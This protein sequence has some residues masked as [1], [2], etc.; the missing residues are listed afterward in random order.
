MNKVVFIILMGVSL[1][2]FSK[3]LN[4]VEDTSRGINK[5]IASV[6]GDI[7]TLR[8]LQEFKRS[9]SID[10]SAS[11]SG[12]QALEN[13]IEEKLIVQLAEKEKFRVD[14]SLVDKKM[15]QLISAYGGYNKLEESLAKAGLSTAIIIKK[16]KDNLL[17]REAV[18]K[19]VGSKISISPIEVTEYY[20]KHVKEFS[21]LPEYICWITK[22]GKKDFLDGLSVKIKEEGFNQ[23]LTE[24]K[25]IFFRV[26]S[27]EKG[28]NDEVKEVVKSIKEGQWKIKY[29]EGAYYL[30]YLSKIVPGHKAFINEVR[31]KIYKRLWREKFSKKFEEWIKELKEKSVIK[32]YPAE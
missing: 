9:S 29:I 24:R 17:I 12:E 22:S 28:L 16:V 14:N 25:D 5:I 30:V 19:Y 2:C 8:D 20:K 6:N 11:I 15:K 31:D 7:I 1:A 26:E 32:I 23:L 21:S 10:K 18:S 13:L 3:G 27:D 4:S